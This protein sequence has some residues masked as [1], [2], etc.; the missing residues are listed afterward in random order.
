M[1]DANIICE[2]YRLQIYSWCHTKRMIDGTPPAY[3]SFG[4][5][6]TKILKDA[7]LWQT[8]H[9]RHSGS[10]LGTS[11]QEETNLSRG[12]LRLR[13]FPLLVPNFMTKYHFFLFH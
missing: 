11:Q 10:N 1:D 9:I 6:M 7:F 13:L 8:T 4:L 2:G 5:T 3:P 12:S